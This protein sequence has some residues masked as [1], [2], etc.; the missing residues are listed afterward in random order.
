MRNLDA[1]KILW[2]LPIIFLIHNMEEFPFLQ[3]WANERIN[4]SRF[5]LFKDLYQLSNIAI[6]M[7]LLTLAVSIVIWMEYKKRNYITFNLTFLCICLLLI[8]GIVHVGQFFL[9]KRYVPGLITAVLLLIP[10]MTYIIYLFIKNNDIKTREVIK[11]LVISI[12]IMSPIIFLFLL[13]S[14]WFAKLISSLFTE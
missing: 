13:I 12:I 5:G 10:Y 9:Y 6:A 3:K 8:N 11:Y 1:Y 2:L 14:N 7:I 4:D